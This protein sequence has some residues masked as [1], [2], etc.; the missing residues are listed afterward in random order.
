MNT[1]NI[2]KLPDDDT[3]TIVEV[4]GEVPDDCDYIE[5]YVIDGIAY[6]V[7]RLADHRI[8]AIVATDPEA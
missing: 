2:G 6:D 5:T 3:D 1:I 7:H 8:V 4:L